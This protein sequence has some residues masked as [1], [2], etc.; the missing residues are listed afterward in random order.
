MGL[1]VLATISAGGISLGES[2]KIKSGIKS[3]MPFYASINFISLAPLGFLKPR[4]CCAGMASRA[5]GCQA[6]AFRRVQV[7]DSYPGCRKVQNRYSTGPLLAGMELLILGGR[8][9]HFLLHF[10][11]STLANP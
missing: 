5:P 3:G 9:T 7:A 11:V 6:L 1:T 10:R 8:Q 2:S 4:L